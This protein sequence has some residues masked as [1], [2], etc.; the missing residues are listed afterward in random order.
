VIDSISNL[1]VYNDSEIVREFFYHIINRT[2]ARGIHTISLAVEEE[3][4]ESQINRLMYLND[5]ILKVRDSF[6]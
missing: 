6:I 5:K 3:G 1:I 4:I 2:R